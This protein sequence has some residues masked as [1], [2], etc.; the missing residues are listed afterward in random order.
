MIRKLQQLMLGVLVRTEAAFDSV[1]GAHW[2]PWYQ[3]GALSFHFF[4][5][6]VV[7]GVYLYVFFDT[8]ILGAY[9]LSLIHI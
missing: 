6:V 5:I 3:L 1:F 7:S 4:W 9:A 8:S 2:N